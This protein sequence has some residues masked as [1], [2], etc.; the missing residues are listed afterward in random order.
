MIC[1]SSLAS[2][3]LAAATTTPRGG[4]SASTITLRS[5]PSLARSEGSGPISPL[6]NAPCP[7]RHRRSMPPILRSS[8]QSL[9]ERL[10]RV[11]YSSLRDELLH[12]ESFLGIGGVRCATDCW[13]MDY[14]HYRPHSSLIAWPRLFSQ[15]YVLS[16]APV[17]SAL[18]N[19]GR[20]INR[21]PENWPVQSE[22]NLVDSHCEKDSEYE[23]QEVHG[24]ADCLGCTHFG[25]QEP[26]DNMAQKDM[27]FI[28]PAPLELPK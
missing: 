14:D 19:R 1:L 24:A 13:W 12:R 28:Y 22:R 3:T 18:L 9:W 17:P 16:K 21:F 2:G 7:F 23:E 8:W 4:P 10:C 20:I 15:R 25:W 27:P 26:C 6:R 11:L 5:M